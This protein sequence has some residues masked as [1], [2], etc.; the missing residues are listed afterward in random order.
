VVS[1]QWLVVSPCA[2]PWDCESPGGPAPLEERPLEERP[3]EERPLE[4][5]PL[6]ERPLGRARLP[7]SR[8]QTH[9][10][11]QIDALYSHADI[12]QP[13]SAAMQ[14]APYCCSASQ[15][16]AE[17]PQK[18]AV[19]KTGWQYGPAVRHQTAGTTNAN[20]PVKSLGFRFYKPRRI[21]CQT[22]EN[23]N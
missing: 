16:T 7:P 4:E 6:E 19:E 11:P 8:T 20:N 3:L 2:A 13:S 22:G 10:R 17:S 9:D 15:R 23:A 14:A 18:P 1:G 5:R 12:G 21:R